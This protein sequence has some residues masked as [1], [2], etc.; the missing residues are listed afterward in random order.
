MVKP[1]ST[2]PDPTDSPAPTGAA[3]I[4]NEMK[5]LPAAPGVYRIE[6]AKG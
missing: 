2:S 6:N 1:T 3:L 5:T 4:R